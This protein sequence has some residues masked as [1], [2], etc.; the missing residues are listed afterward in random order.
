MLAT[1][2]LNGSLAVSTYPYAHYGLNVSS[3]WPCGQ[4][5]ETRARYAKTAWHS[6]IQNKNQFCVEYAGLGTYFRNNSREK[7]QLLV[8][9]AA[10]GFAPY[11]GRKKWGKSPSD[12][13]DS[14]Q[15]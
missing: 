8:T 15:E 1:D 12:R 7:I 6:G 3:E 14:T 13:H 9:T 5:V 4:P 10:F 2:T 11:I